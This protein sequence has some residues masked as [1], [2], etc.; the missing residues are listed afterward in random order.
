MDTPGT[1]KTESHHTLD[2][3]NRED[4]SSRVSKFSSSK[5]YNPE[6]FVKRTLDWKRAKDIK[7]EQMR[8]DKMKS[9]LNS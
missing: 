8:Q 6:Q 4:S 3:K 9:D 5:N 2:H 7:I 1:I